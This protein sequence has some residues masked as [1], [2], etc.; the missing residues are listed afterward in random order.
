MERRAFTVSIPGEEHIKEADYF[1]MV[2]GRDQQKLKK[3]GLKPVKSNLV[4]APYIEEFP[5]VLECKVI[6]IVEIGLHTQF[7]GEI[8]DVKAEESAIND[9]NAPAVEIVKPAIYSPGD[10]GY[11]AIGR[12]LGPAYTIGK[13]F[14]N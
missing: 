10:R 8:V 6:K 4:D 14:S 11:N 13:D 5:L 2:S 3:T 7:I 9:R 1:G 12:F